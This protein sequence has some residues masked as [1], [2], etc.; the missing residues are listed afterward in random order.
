MHFVPMEADM[1]KL[2]MAVFLTGALSQAAVAQIET[3]KVT[4]GTVQGVVSDG[5][6]IFKGSSHHLDQWFHFDLW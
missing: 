5:L 1:M 6:S 3:V 2:L 4:G